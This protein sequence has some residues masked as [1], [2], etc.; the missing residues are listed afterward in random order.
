MSKA[1]H[2]RGLTILRCSIAFVLPIL[3][4]FAVWLTL[5][6]IGGAT[7]AVVTML[8]CLLWGFR[9][10]DR[11][12]RCFP[13]EATELKSIVPRWIDSRDRR[14]VLFVLQAIAILAT[15]P[16]AI[17]VYHALGLPELFP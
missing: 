14:T 12:S 15:W 6:G 2:W 9:T 1:Y 11:I 4:S 17:E 10:C 5:A 7:I 13:C 16:I 3:L 8:Y